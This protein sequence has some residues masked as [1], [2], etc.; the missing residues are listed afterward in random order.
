MK[1]FIEFDELSEIRNIPTFNK[2]YTT[3]GIGSI[4]E[5]DTTNETLDILESLTN[6]VLQLNNRNK[7]NNNNS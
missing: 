6:L 7:S 5:D 1:A 4:N 2:I 3:L